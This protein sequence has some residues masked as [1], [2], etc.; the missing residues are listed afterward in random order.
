MSVEE[1]RVTASF[2]EDV[3]QEAE[4]LNHGSL[5]A[6]ILPSQSRSGGTQRL[7]RL[8]ICR[9][10]CSVHVFVAVDFHWAITLS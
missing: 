3:V 9:S 5:P 1:I 2:D 10:W 8:L 6:P 7:S 4:E